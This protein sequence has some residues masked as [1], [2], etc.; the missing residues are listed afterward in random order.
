MDPDK[1]ARSG[2]S[3]EYLCY[4]TAHHHQVRVDYPEVEHKT[5]APSQ[6]QS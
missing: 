2:S 1:S 6:W 5:A 3:L 4:M